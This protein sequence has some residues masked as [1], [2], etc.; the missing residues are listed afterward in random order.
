MTTEQTLFDLEDLTA[1]PAEEYTPKAMREL[2]FAGLILSLEEAIERERP[3]SNPDEH[4]LNPDGSSRSGTP[5]WQAWH[6]ASGIQSVLY[7]VRNQLAT[8][9]EHLIAERKRINASWNEQE[10]ECARH[11]D[12]C[13]RCTE[14]S[15]AAWKAQRE[16]ER[17]GRVAAALLSGVTE[18]QYAIACAAEAQ[19]GLSAAEISKALDKVIKKAKRLQEWNESDQPK[20][21]GQ[22]L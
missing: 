9:E 20:Q 5:Y 6:R 1:T 8:H 4:L 2:L 7:L 15:H 21:G 19:Q 3:G 10:I 22:H 14:T 18:V 13:P 16:V 17:A 11:R 12:A